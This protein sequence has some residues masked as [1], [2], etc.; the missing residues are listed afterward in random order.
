MYSLCIL[1]GI[2]LGGGLSYY[3]IKRE[4]KNI[5]DFIV[6]AS[7]TYF[8]AFIAAKVLYIFVSYKGKEVIKVFLSILLDKKLQQGG[9]IF[10]GGLIG[11]VLG[12]I[13]GCK[14]MKVKY[15]SYIN[16]IAVVLPLIHA[17]G[18]LGCFCAGCCYGREMKGFFC[19]TYNNP[20]SFAP[21]GKSLFAVQLLEAL[22]LLAIFTVLFFLYLKG[23]RKEYLV[24]LLLYSLMRFLIE[25][26]R[27]DEYRGSIFNLS[28]SQAISVVLFVLSASL[29]IVDRI[30]YYIGR[31][32]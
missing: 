20:L 15:A 4:N 17:W 2:T 6:L 11:G 24:Y 10:Y 12:Y 8:V 7:L 19:V 18:R 29:F 1:A 26:L 25:F 21:L 13:L 9:F 3:F 31:K 16:I 14:L 27:G 30:R 32:Q 28:T 5:Y 23:Y 22:I